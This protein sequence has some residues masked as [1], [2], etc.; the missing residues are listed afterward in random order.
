M[1]I[2]R[3]FIRI[4]GLLLTVHLFAVFSL[5]GTVRSSPSNVLTDSPAKRTAVGQTAD[6]I[7]SRRTPGPGQDVSQEPNQVQWQQSDMIYGDLFEEE[8]QD[9]FTALHKTA[10]HILFSLSSL[11]QRASDPMQPTGR[12][13]KIY[14]LNSSLRC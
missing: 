6:P 11:Y 14:L 1:R 8:S 2:Q 10:P 7:D 13:T 3:D 4:A 12:P 5:L 9:L